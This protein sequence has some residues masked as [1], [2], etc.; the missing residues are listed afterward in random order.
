MF[1][2]FKP[3]PMETSNKKY[4]YILSN[5]AWLFIKSVIQ[6]LLVATKDIH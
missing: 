1:I 4:M 5:D 3:E 2:Y 6:N